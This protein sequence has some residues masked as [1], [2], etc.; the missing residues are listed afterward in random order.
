M[1]QFC[2]ERLKKDLIVSCRTWEEKRGP[3]AGLGSAPPL[4]AFNSEQGMLLFPTLFP[5][6]Y[7]KAFELDD[8]QN[9]LDKV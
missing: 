3:G 6:L 7:N 4:A 8:M 1:G 9:P 2:V 5:Q